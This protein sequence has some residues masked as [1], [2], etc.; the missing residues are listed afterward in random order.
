MSEV[1]YCHTCALRDVD[2]ASIRFDNYGA[3]LNSPFWNEEDCWVPDGTIP[4][5]EYE[6]IAVR[7]GET[8][9]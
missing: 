4:V 5:Y 6:L 7:N 8:D 9:E 2:C 3:N 1:N